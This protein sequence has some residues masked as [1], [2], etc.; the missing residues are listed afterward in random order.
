MSW[1]DAWNTLSQ[2]IST[3]LISEVNRV[4]SVINYVNSF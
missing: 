1:R 2:W 3:T 4:T